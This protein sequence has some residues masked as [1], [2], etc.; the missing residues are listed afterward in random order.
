MVNY[1]RMVKKAVRKYP[2]FA[3]RYNVYKPAI[4]QLAS[5]VMYI[6]GLINSEPKNV[7]YTNNGTF[8][9]NGVII[10]LSDTVQGDGAESRDGNRLLPRYL[11]IKGH[12][13][14]AISGTPADHVT[15]RYVLFRWWGE[16]PNAAGVPPIPSD[17]L[18]DI[19]TAFAPTSFLSPQITG[20]KGDRN[21]R[22]EVHRSGTISL[23]RI[24]TNAYD[25]SENIEINNGASNKPKEHIE[26]WSNA[27]TIPTSGG[28]FMLF[29]SDSAVASECNYH[30]NGHLTFYDN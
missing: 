20:Q 4:K 28:F 17:I 1:N 18:R 8:D 30:V 13:R 9:Y 22:I 5:D 12:I 3:K 23:D 24:N 19:G 29:I 21:R 26:Y 25:F 11:G 6:K 2:A 16:S 10:N 14:K 7:Y 27:S 15:V